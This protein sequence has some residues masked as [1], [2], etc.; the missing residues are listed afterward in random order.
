[1]GRFRVSMHRL[2]TAIGGTLEPP[3]GKNLADSD[4]A[5]LPRRYRQGGLDALVSLAD[6][7]PAG[8]RRWKSVVGI[9]NST[10]ISIYASQWRDFRGAGSEFGLPI[11]RLRSKP[12]YYQL[13][14][15]RAQGKLLRDQDDA[16]AGLPWDE[17]PGILRYCL[18]TM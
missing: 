6:C 13:L 5:H 2:P 8:A 18:R 10:D 17:V 12:G 15:G 1:M 7:Q 14:D 11:P 16:G 9:E 4:G 3:L